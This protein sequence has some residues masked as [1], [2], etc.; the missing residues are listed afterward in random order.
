MYS[1]TGHPKYRAPEINE[2]SGYSEKC[3]MFSTGQIL[4][5]FSTG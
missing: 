5:A 4:Y 1:A 2:G 3:D